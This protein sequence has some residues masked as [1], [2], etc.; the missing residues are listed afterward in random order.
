MLERFLG[1]NQPLTTDNPPSLSLVATQPNPPPQAFLVQNAFNG[2]AEVAN[3]NNYPAIRM[4]TTKKTT[5]QTA[6]R[7]LAPVEQVWS[8]SSNVSISQDNKAGSGANDDDWLYMSA[9]CYFYAQRVF[10]GLGST[11]PIGLVRA[12]Y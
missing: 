9:M 4:M 6:Q 2:A 3:A 7:E 11:T 12:Q 10:K 1:T 8:V 5:Q